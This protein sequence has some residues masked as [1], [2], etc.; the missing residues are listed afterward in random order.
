[1]FWR[2]YSWGYRTLAAALEAMTEEIAEGRL[3]AVDCRVQAYRTTEGA[4]RWQIQELGP[5]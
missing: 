3:S 5:V 2:S 1:M 4:R